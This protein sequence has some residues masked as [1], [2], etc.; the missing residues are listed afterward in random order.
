VA[1][2]VVFPDISIGMTNDRIVSMVISIKKNGVNVDFIFVIV[3]LNALRKISII[4]I[5]SK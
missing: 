4:L 5:L 3:F 1:D 2:G